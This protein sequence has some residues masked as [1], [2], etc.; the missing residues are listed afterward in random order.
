MLPKYISPQIDL[1]R[2]LAAYDAHRF[3]TIPY[4]PLKY[5]LKVYPPALNVSAQEEKFLPFQVQYTIPNA[6]T[7]QPWMTWLEG[8]GRCVCC[9]SVHGGTEAKVKGCGG[10][11]NNPTYMGA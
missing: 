5:E 4:N 3:L 8:L 7:F 9:V 6:D 10:G 11:V 2:I 1:I